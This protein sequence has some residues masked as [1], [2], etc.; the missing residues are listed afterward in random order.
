MRITSI[1]LAGKIE[2]N[3]KLPRAFARITRKIGSDQIEV[4]ILM[5]GSERVHH[6]QADNEED[7][8][9]M[10]ECLQYHLDGGKGTN[11]MIHDYYRELQ[12]FAD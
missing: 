11:S 3:S 12:R 7:L 9:S 4:T 2:K 1:E 8:W 10:A 6:V 5:P